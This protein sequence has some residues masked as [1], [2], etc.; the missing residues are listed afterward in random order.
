MGSLLS[1][2]LVTVICLSALVAASV[3]VVPSSTRPP[4]SAGAISPA[5]RM[6]PQSNAN[7]HMGAN[8]STDAVNVSYSETFYNTSVPVNGTVTNIGALRQSMTLTYRDG[9][10]ASMSFGFVCFFNPGGVNVTQQRV[11]NWSRLYEIDP[12]IST[13]TYEDGLLIYAGY[14]FQGFQIVNGSAVSFS[15]KNL[16][17]GSYLYFLNNIVGSISYFTSS[18]MIGAVTLSNESYVYQNQTREESVATFN[19]TIQSVLSNEKLLVYSP[20]ARSVTVP[21]VLSFTVTHN[22]TATEYKY[23]ASLNW[24]SATEF[25]TLEPMPVGQT[26]VVVAQDLVSC[27]YSNASAN[28]PTT[29]L[30]A[31]T[32][33]PKNGS[34]VYTAGANQICRELFTTQ[35]TLNGNP[36]VLDTTRIYMANQSAEQGQVMSSMFVVYS[37]FRYGQST[38]FSFDPAVIAPN[39]VVPSTGPPHTNP[40]PPSSSSNGSNPNPLLPIG[41]VAAVAVVAVLA[42]VLVIRR[43]RRK[44]TKT[45]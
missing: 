41:I 39:A 27:S 17:N 28:G 11:L 34:A 35:Y 29:T 25:P 24:S 7:W 42:G 31:F 38:G 8:E 10:E 1:T 22:L 18:G 6:H 45:G 19:V 26:Y 23:G 37:G 13:G 43:R 20:D 5:A 15:Y 33:D 21:T 4:T 32:T 44:A 14:N 3:T 2:C 36:S 40:G 12:I 9:T 30:S 16:S